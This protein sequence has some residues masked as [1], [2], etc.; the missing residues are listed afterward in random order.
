MDTT[1]PQRKLVFQIF[2]TIAN[3]SAAS[4]KGRN[5]KRKTKDCSGA[6]KEKSETALNLYSSKQMSVR[7]VE[8]RAI[9]IGRDTLYRAIGEREAS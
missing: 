3:S 6:D 9:G 7:E 5:T 4:S 1:T 8:E 2:S